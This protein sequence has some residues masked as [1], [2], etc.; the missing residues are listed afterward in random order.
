MSKTECH[1]GILIWRKSSYSIGNGNCV[2][3]AAAHGE[4]I[5]RD[6]ASPA[7]GQLLFTAEAWDKFTAVIKG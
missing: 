6:T 1:E 2:E 4:V 7:R 3:A 5:V